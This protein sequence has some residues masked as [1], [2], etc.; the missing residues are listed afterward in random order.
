ML[1]QSS[2]T[3]LINRAGGAGALQMSEEKT[4][5]SLEGVGNPK[6]YFQLDR[7]RPPTFEAKKWK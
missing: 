3:T 5:K 2:D 1:G 4:K 7:K 6:L